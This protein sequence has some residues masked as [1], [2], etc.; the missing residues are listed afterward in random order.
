VPT[1]LVC[2]LGFLQ[3]KNNMS[4][5]HESME[6]IPEDNNHPAPEEDLKTERCFS[7]EACDMGCDV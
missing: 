4:V 3:T 5:H 7:T 6:E 1:L 2:L